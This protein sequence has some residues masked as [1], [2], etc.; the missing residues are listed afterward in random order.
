MRK[1]LFNVFILLVS[2]IALG[3]SLMKVTPFSING[4][5]YIGTIATFIGI[6]VTLLIGYQLINFIEIRKELTEFKKSKSEIFDTQ[7]RISKLE[8]EIQENLD[9]ISASFIS[10]NQGGCVEAFLLQ[11]RAMI[12]ALKSK[13]TDFEHL[14]IGLKQYITKMEPSY[15]ATGGNTEVDERFAKY[16]EDSEKYDLE[17]KANDNYY[18]IKH[19]YERIMKCFYTRL[20]NARKLIAVSQEEYSDIMR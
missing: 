15:F 17:I 14:Y 9:A 10:M 4:D 7:K 3:F 12:S 6:S 13:R 16:K 18:I 11:Q 5:T 20:D 1:T 2:L 19:E 8:N